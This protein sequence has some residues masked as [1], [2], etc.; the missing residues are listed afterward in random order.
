MWRALR[1]SASSF[2]R[3]GKLFEALQN[4]ARVAGSAA[5]LNPSAAGA[6]QLRVECAELP[7]G[8]PLSVDAAWRPVE[9]LKLVARQEAADPI[10]A[11]SVNG[12]LRGLTEPLGEH[13]EPSVRL[14][15]IRFAQPDGASVFWHSAAHVLGAALES[16]FGAVAQ[17]TDGPAL[18]PSDG[19]GMFYELHFSE[20]SLRISEEV[21]P[22]LLAAAKVTAAARHPFERLIISRE[23]AGELF[24]D[25]PF[26][27]DMLSRIPE[28]QVIT[29]YRSGPFVDLC[30]GPHLPHTGLL[31]HM[32]I[33]RASGSHWQATGKDS[34]IAGALLQR[35]YG[36]A[37]PT[38]A[39]LA[40]WVAARE[41]AAKRDHR[42]VGTAQGLFMFHELSPGSA[43]LLPPGTRIV[44]RLLDMM[45]SQYRARG[46]EEVATPQMYKRG[47]WAT[48]GHGDAYADNMYAV[49]PGLPAKG[50]P[51]RPASG[52]CGH[53]HAGG[54]GGEDGSE[55]EVFGLKPMNCPGHCLLVAARTLSHR[56]LPL[57]LADFSSLHRNEASGGLGGLTRLRRFHQDDAHVFCRP[58]QVQAEVAACLDF[59]AAIYDLFGFTFRCTLS[60]RPLEGSV[61]DDATWVA[62]EGA[63]GQ[64]LAAFLSTRQNAMGGAGS[65]EGGPVPLEVDV[66]GGAFYG[67]KIDIFVRDAL[68]REHQCATVQLDFNLP[69]RFSIKYKTPEG[70]MERPVMI[71]RAIFG[72]VERFLAV[73]IEHTAGKWPFWLSP[74]QVLVCTVAE[75]HEPYARALLERLMFPPTAPS[76]PLAPA[77]PGTIAS[78][79][80]GREGGGAHRDSGLWGEVDASARSVPKKVR[81]GTLDAWNL[82][83]VVGDAEEAA[84]TAAVR[85]RDAATAAAFARAWAEVDA[86]AVA[87]RP[88]AADGTGGGAYNSPVV[89]VGVETLRAVCECMARI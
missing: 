74:R 38:N 46:Y 84:G 28:G 52:G 54:G 87:P 78:S 13:A 33:N 56:D 51:V 15:F 14:E 34:A 18:G 8:G 4:D 44:N 55:D 29:A 85:F 25:N 73:L 45:R 83:A 64:A 10:V 16:H 79:L 19:G 40:G 12:V 80:L 72:S 81:E 43:F 66:G 39:G 65:R 20:P 68:G 88:S 30:R 7:G 49:L 69:T 27:L 47:L 21:F 76:G 36:V 6:A 3:R 63:L 75:R 35:A 24:S 61:G 82:V 48:S 23:A 5:L 32:L 9:A 86:A 57:R 62:A 60:T 31:K 22:A 2:A 1:R 53:G 17:L 41:A 37:F 67:P 58:D 26:K 77:E 11:V 71:H 50:W 89:S 70:G 59:V 42:V